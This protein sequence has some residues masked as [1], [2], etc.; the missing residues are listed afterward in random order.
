[1]PTEMKSVYSSH[2]DEIG[3]DAEAKELVVKFTN[4]RTAIYEEVPPEKASE[5]MAA[6]SIGEALSANIRGKFPFRYV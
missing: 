3:Y 6:P 2:V 5:I 1:M 4:G